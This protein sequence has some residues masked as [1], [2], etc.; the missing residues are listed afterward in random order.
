VPVRIELEPGTVHGHL[1]EPTTTGG[2]RSL[3]R[4]AAWLRAPAPPK[5]A[6]T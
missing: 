4:M 3:E 1:N 5:E 6:E 2:E